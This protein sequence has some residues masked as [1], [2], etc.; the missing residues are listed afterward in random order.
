MRHSQTR[1]H[2]ERNTNTEHSRTS[3]IPS[4]GGI[5]LSSVR[6]PLPRTGLGKKAERRLSAGKL[7]SNLPCAGSMSWEERFYV[8][9]DIRQPVFPLSF[10][11][12]SL[13]HS[14]VIAQPCF[15]YYSCLSYLSWLSLFV[16]IKVLCCSVIK[17]WIRCA[18]PPRIVV[19]KKLQWKWK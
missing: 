7:E 9:K 11:L 2:F 19:Q 1:L 8:E 12:S 10:V 14:L 4:A 3:T 15:L 13:S 5:T 6:V 16:S 18:P 17:D